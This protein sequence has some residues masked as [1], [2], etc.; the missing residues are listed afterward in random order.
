MKTI[1]HFYMSNLK[2]FSIRKVV[3][4]A[5]SHIIRY[6]WKLDLDLKMFFIFRVT[7]FH[8]NFDDSYDFITTTI[9]TSK[10]I[11]KR[12]QSPNL[13]FN[14]SM[15]T[16]SKKRTIHRTL[17]AY[18]IENHLSFRAIIIILQMRGGRTATK[19]YRKFEF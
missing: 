8:W 4:I 15:Q 19:I 18:W 2:F 17:T 6:N 11:M 1:F 13:L 10:S 14:R 12:Q 5:R 7:S 9:N 3:W 16:L